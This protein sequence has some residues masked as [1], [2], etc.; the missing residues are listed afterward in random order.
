MIERQLSKEHVKVREL[1]Y[2]KPKKLDNIIRV[3]T[4][5]IKVHLENQIKAGVDIV[6]IFDTH[7]NHMDS[8]LFDKYFY[9]EIGNII[10]D[11]KS[12]FPN[13]YISL[14]TKSNHILNDAIY[15]NI[16]CISFNSHVK[17]K[18]YIRK[19]PNEICFQGNLDPMRLAVGGQS[20]VEATEGILKDMKTK[21]FVF[22][23]G[24][25][26]LPQT[27][28]ENVHLLIDTIRSFKEKA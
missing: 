27:P 16:D 6:Q 21:N 18:D 1:A 17:M 15:K 2:K 23:L 20:L 12:K 22:N 26:V 25:G 8:L 28:V 24:H 10:K 5:L 4:K 3:L 13:I 19:I 11:I 9:K 7:A 14:F